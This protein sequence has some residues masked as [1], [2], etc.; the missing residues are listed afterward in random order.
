MTLASPAR[1]QFRRSAAEPKDRMAST[2]GSGSGSSDLHSSYWSRGVGTA[3]RMSVAGPRTGR[4]E[5]SLPKD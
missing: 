5:R 4:A 1:P 3:K 2:A